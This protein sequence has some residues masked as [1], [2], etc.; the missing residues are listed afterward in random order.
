M[1]TSSGPWE[2]DDA[3]AAPDRTVWSGEECVATVWHGTVLEGEANAKLIAAA[4]DLL[5]ALGM[6]VSGCDEL[7]A[8][9][10]N[11]LRDELDRALD[12]ISKAVGT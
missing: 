5:V 6:L 3:T 4:P 9:C 8:M 1:S 11:E 12:A 2:I 7:P 10:R